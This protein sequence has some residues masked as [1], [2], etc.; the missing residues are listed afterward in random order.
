MKD[1]FGGECTC[2]T[3]PFPRIPPQI[4]SVDPWTLH[5]NKKI[6]QAILMARVQSCATSEDA[7]KLL[8]DWLETATNIKEKILPDLFFTE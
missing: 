3:P 7:E 6:A 5:S 8:D 1:L 2:G 4:L